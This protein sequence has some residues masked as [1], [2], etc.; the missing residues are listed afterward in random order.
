MPSN[1]P[2]AIRTTY[3]ISKD[4]DNLGIRVLKPPGSE[5]SLALAVTPLSTASAKSFVVAQ[6]QMLRIS[7]CFGSNLSMGSFRSGSRCDPSSGA[8]HLRTLDHFST[9]PRHNPNDMSVTARGPTMV[10]DT[11]VNIMVS[12]LSL[13]CTLKRLN[14]RTF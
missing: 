7:Y 2:T 1:M 4:A 8:A 13:L 14:R 11:A 3:K 6:I 10:V 5:L 9:A 12:G